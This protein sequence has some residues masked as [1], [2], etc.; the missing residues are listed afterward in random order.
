MP[1]QDQIIG[2]MAFT[3]TMTLSLLKGWPAD[4]LTHQSAP[5][6]NHVLWV[7][8]HL[9]GTDAWICDLVGAPRVQAPETLLKACGMG[10][11][12]TKNAA[13][14][15]PLPEMLKLLESA[16]AGL[17]SWL[18]SATPAQLSVPLNDKTQGFA[19]DPADALYKLVWHE[20]WHAG[21]IASLRKSLGLAPI[22]G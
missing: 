5:T 7:I 19:D 22:M 8:G 17:V 1:S 10:S 11:K 13:D 4:K 6:D 16:R 20:G 9:I 18:K 2:L 21:Q 3:R 12:P 14:Y 15:A